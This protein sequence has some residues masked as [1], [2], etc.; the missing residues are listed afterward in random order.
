MSS[1]ESE[2]SATRESKRRLDTFFRSLSAGAALVL[3]YDGTL[4]PFRVERSL[5]V[6]Y[7]GVRESL[8]AILAAEGT[9]VVLISGRAPEE[10]RDLL[11]I[12]PP[13][14]IWGVHGQRRLWP[15]GHTD[16]VPVRASDQRALDQAAGWV[17]H[18][19]FTEMAE[20]KPGSI[21]LHWRGMPAEQAGQAREAV[22][23]EWG[24]LADSAGM[25]LLEFD[26]GMELRP[27]EPNKG[28]AVLALRA[29]LG[30][31]SP[32]AFLGDDATDEDAF[33][34]LSGTTA[35]TVLVRPEW[36]ESAACAWIRPPEE[37]L[38]F[39]DE[40]RKRSGARE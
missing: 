35:L 23:G 26:G 10:V 24:G 2:E 36:R 8:G 12:D 5:A 19:G 28:S 7:P 27:R 30:P 13:P 4:A 17:A 32:F 25:S 20:F 11:A 38:W 40:W 31:D 29:E 9:R 18:H 15:D 16:V 33:R 39:L 3:D 21:A 1:V 37:L 14:E 34:A 22:R 6:P